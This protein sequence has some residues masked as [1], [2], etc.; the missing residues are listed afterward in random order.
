M[1]TFDPYDENEALTAANLSAR[2]TTMRTWVNALPARSVQRW[3]LDAQHVPPQ[4]YGPSHAVELFPNGFQAGGPAL[5]ATGV[6]HDNSLA[7]SAG[8]AHPLNYQD[9]SASGVDAPYGPVSGDTGGG[10]RIPSQAAAAA[11]ME[12]TFDTP[13]F[14]LDTYGLTLLVRARI[15]VYDA[16]AGYAINDED[17]DYGLPTANEEVFSRCALI[18]IGFEDGLG[19][20]YVIERTVRWNNIFGVARG[21]IST[22]TLLKQEDL[23]AGNGTIAKVFGVVANNRWADTGLTDPPPSFD[24]AIR[25]YTISAIPFR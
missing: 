16:V 15:E 25:T 17:K 22:M 24:L 7:Y 8:P 5:G 14:R 21:T 12:L 9:F 6:V 13:A 11:K 18:G 3:G 20:R 1:P 23:A 4:T 10:W 19:A 2:L